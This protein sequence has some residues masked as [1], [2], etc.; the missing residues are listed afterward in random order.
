[1]C[2]CVCVCMCVRVCVCINFG[3]SCLINKAINV[4]AQNDET[5]RERE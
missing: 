3:L 5:I 1:M 2:V 4:M